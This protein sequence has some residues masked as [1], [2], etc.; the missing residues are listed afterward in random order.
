M[1]GTTPCKRWWIGAQTARRTVRRHHDYLHRTMTTINVNTADEDELESCWMRRSEQRRRSWRD[2]DEEIRRPCRPEVCRRHRCA[3][4]RCEG[5]A[6]LFQMIQAV[7]T[8]LLAPLCMLSTDESSHRLCS[9]RHEDSH[10]RNYRLA[11]FLR[12]T[13]TSISTAAAIA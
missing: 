3:D 8:G 10:R 7:M 5:A 12:N 6:D 11:F 9:E 2:V 13:S 1:R 4:D